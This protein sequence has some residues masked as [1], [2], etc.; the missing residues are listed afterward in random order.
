MNVPIGLEV[1]WAEVF[2]VE[3]LE[4]TQGLVLEVTD[5]RL[6][7]RELIIE[8]LLDLVFIVGPFFLLFLDRVFGT[9]AF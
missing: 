4:Q 5:F 9:T 2:L 6:H 3:L 7:G 1:L 8:F